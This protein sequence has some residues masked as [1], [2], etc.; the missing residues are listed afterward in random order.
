MKFPATQNFNKIQKTIK[1]N[2]KADTIGNKNLMSKEQYK[3]KQ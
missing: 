3:E 1:R 2:K